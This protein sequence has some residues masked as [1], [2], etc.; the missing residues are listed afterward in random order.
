MKAATLNRAFLMAGIIC[1]SWTAAQASTGTYIAPD[2]TTPYT[3]DA[4]HTA[5]WT[6]TGI[7]GPLQGFDVQAGSIGTAGGLFLTLYDN[8]T[9]TSMIPTGG[10]GT[11]SYTQF[12]LQGGTD[13]G[14]GYNPILLDFTAAPLTLNPSDSYTATLSYTGSDLGYK[15][16]ANGNPGTLSTTDVADAPEPGSLSMIGL[17]VVA[18]LAGHKWTKK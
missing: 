4:S 12:Q 9:S 13:Y 16:L 5:T 3:V 10:F 18:M 17:G 1:A 15:V 6:F 14:T 8:T 2:G 11:I 7:S